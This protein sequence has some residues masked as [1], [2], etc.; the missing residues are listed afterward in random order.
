M[1]LFLDQENVR[2]SE[3]FFVCKIFKNI[4]SKMYIENEKK[5]QRA[6]S[7][8]LEEAAYYELPPLDLGCLQIQFF[9][10]SCLKCYCVSSVVR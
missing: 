7:V 2:E 6:D 5:K 4:I 8:D 1:N 9:H 3:K 10:F